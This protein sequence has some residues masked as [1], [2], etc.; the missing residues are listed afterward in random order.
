[1]VDATR[2]ELVEK[3]VLRLLQ[4]KNARQ[5]FFRQKVNKERKDTRQWMREHPELVAEIQAKH[6][7][8]STSREWTL[9]DGRLVDKEIGND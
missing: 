1:M 9:K 5:R 6:V 3:E 8:I 7:G 4:R 2:T